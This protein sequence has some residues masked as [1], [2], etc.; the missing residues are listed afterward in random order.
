MQR[1]LLVSALVL[2]TTTSVFSINRRMME[3]K[4]MV[5][6]QAS[7]ML[8]MGAYANDVNGAVGAGLRGKYFGTN[9]F[10]FGFD[11][12]FFAPQIKP[13]RLTFVADSV[14]RNVLQEEQRLGRVHD[15]IQILDVTATSQYIPFNVSFEFYLP[16]RSLTNFRPYVG[17]G[18]GLN[19]INRRYK[20]IYNAPKLPGTG[21]PAFEERVQPSSNKGFVSLNPTI[22]FLWT[23]DELWNINMDLRY[24]QLFGGQK[25]GVL[26]VHFGVILDLSFKYVR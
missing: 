4:T 19:M 12:G 15:S 26:S 22:G 9:T 5:G 24:N 25:G 1:K 18:L 14:Y 17:I 20:P 11:F 8:P 16:S 3:D 13:E 21:I 23:L 2:L 7:Y 6:V 10:A